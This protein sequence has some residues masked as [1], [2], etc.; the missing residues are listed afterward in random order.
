MLTNGCFDLLH[1]GHVSYLSAAKAQGD[2][3]VVALNSDAGVRRLKGPGRPLNQFEDR[4]HVVAALSSVDHVVVF[5]EPTPVEIVRAVRP[6]VFVKGG[7]YTADMLPEAPVVR[8]LGG[9]VRILPYVEDRST[10]GLIARI[11]APLLERS[12]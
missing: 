12:A 4:A 6:D 5:D 7:D 8:A 10:T 11:R 3:L 2:V 9:E 1:R